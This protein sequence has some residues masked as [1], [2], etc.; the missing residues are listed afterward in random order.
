MLPLL[1]FLL[2]ASGSYAVY[3]RLHEFELGYVKQRVRDEAQKIEFVLNS[4]KNAKLQAL[5]RMAKRWEVA[6]GTRPPIWRT[7]ARRYTEEF[8]GLKAIEWVDSSYHVRWVE[9]LEGNEKARGLNVLFD[10]QR[11]EAL[12]DAARKSTPTLT[13]P[14]ELV[15]GYTGFIAYVPL[16]VDGKFDGFLAGVFSVEEFLGCAITREIANGYAVS[17]YYKG[18]AYFTNDVAPARS[19][20]DWTIER[21]YRIYDKLW[22]IQVAPSRRIIESQETLLPLVVLLAGLLIGA[23]SALVT[24]YLIVSR[25]TSEH[26]REL[27]RLSWAILSSTTHLVV[28]TDEAGTVVTFNKA[29]EAALG[30]DAHE[31]VGKETPALWHDSAEVAQRASALSVELE[32]RV[33]PG[34]E[35]FIRK[36]LLEGSEVSE[37]T[38]IRR[39]GSRFPGRLTVTPLHDARG[40]AV[41][42]LGVIEDIAERKEQQQALR[43]S[44]EQMRLLVEH[45]PAAVAMF[46]RTLT[47]LM[48][49]R[50]WVQ[51]YGL[52]GREI[53]GKTHYEVFPELLAEPG[54]LDIHQRALAGE[55]FD[56][57]ESSWVREGGKREWINWAVHPWIDNAGDVGGI[58]MFSEVIT[59]RK[60]A[61]EALRVSEETFRAA[62][63][64]APIGMVL[65]SRTGRWLQ[66]NPALCQLLGYSKEELLEKDF[67]SLTYTDD[68]EP[69]VETLVRLLVNE[70]N[71]CQIEKRYYHKRGHLVWTL[72]SVSLM[73]RAD[74]EPDFLIAQ[75]QDISERK[76]MERMKSEFISVVS[77]ELRTPLTS[78]RGSLGLVLGALSRDL[79]AKVKE[80]IGIA[81]NNC[82][83]LILLINDILDIDKIASGHMRFVIKRESLAGLMRQAV[84]DNLPYARSLDTHIALTPIEEGI[85]VEVDASRFIQVLSNL[86]SNAAKFSPP[87]ETITVA[88]ELRGERVRISV[89]D[90]G[91]GIAEEFRPRIFGRFSQADASATR[92]K[93]GTGLGLHISK[94]LVERMAGRI[95]YDTRIGEGTTF[96]VEF[97]LAASSGHVV[98][99]PSTAEPAA[100]LPKP[101]SAYCP[102]VL[103][104]E[105][106]PD[107]S[108]M[109]GTALHDKATI[110]PVTTLQQAEELLRR[111]NFAMILLD[112]K[113]PDGSGLRLLERLDSLTAEPP[114]VVILAADTPPL[115][116]CEQVAAVMVKTRTSE[117]KLV[118]TI[119]DVLE[120]RRPGA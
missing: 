67:Q 117:P 91:I 38:F 80:L 8:S 102:E 27:N 10:A 69:Y 75:I 31:V 14:I 11:R 108:Q 40:D 61:E 37:W 25:H 111:R 50:R 74:G 115:Q 18:K 94:Q 21:S 99:N 89:A 15:Q 106:D 26:L 34:F 6:G 52:E 82:E 84:E 44:A 109:L 104:V 49:S 46:D 56:S 96:W 62:M 20:R 76:E 36:P 12:K 24:R 55:V 92:A 64:H 53:I 120:Q 32:T 35:V 107:L 3:S 118:E 2:F 105:D 54:W 42:Y 30:Y 43:A 73:R 5:E 1:I 86:L 119:L 47:Y 100:V 9:P 103:H 110:I 23:L 72:L 45:T 58:V 33:E 79:P 57:Q 66:V 16:R 116:V 60:E 59:A 29:A 70:I 22:T 17:L 65:V 28:A 48:T 63:E 85:E 112:I 90:N 95:G 19:G 68:L 78:I 77:H 51:D 81:H 13:P 4:R 93:G 87:G 101:L 7:D 97:P 88:A 39:D 114:P 98:S 41:G 83:R 113:L 71:A